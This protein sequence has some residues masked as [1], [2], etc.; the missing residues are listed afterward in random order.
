M[1]H[2][3]SRIA[4]VA[5]TALRALRGVSRKLATSR[6]SGKASCESAGGL[7]RSGQVALA[8]LDVPEREL[9][10]GVRVETELDPRGDPHDRRQRTL[11]VPPA[12]EPT[13]APRH[14]GVDD[15]VDPGARDDRADVLRIGA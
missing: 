1:T 12:E 11:P 3:E 5:L 10:L 6:F 13:R 9:G 14:P 4:P 8:H 15:V 2:G 7:G